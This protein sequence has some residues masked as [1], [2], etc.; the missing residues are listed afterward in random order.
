MNLDLERALSAVADRAT[1]AASPVPVD[2]LVMR[3]HRKRIAQTATYSAIGVGAA[4]AVTIVAIAA[5]GALTDRDPVPPATG[6]PTST[7]TQ[8]S[9]ANP[10][11]TTSPTATEVAWAPNWDL[12]GMPAEDFQGQD[13]NGPGEAPSG[14]QVFVDGDF[15]T[16]YPVDEPVGIAVSAGLWGMPEQAVEA[17]VT[18]VVALGTDEEFQSTYVVGIAAGPTAAVTRG[19]VSE[20]QPLPVEP[21]TTSIVSCAASPLA[22]GDGAL[23][24]R[25]E[26][27]AYYLEAVVDLAT[28]NGTI[29]AV[30]WLGYLGQMPAWYVPE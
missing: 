13:T 20:D 28:E 14:W 15:E 25:L 10:T 23:D 8:T 11:P 2:R 19:T 21:F 22:G 1:A 24:T 27:G 16:A 7:P 9:Q 17:R 30:T 3:L 12:C 5:N 4:A 18:D 6:A 29:T 26:E